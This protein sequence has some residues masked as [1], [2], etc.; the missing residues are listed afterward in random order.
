M[1]VDNN[2]I[3]GWGS[4]CKC[5]YNGISDKDIKDTLLMKEGPKCSLY[6]VNSV[7]RSGLREQEI[8]DLF[9]PYKLQYK[10][11]ELYQP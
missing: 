2:R 10:T 6:T 4:T 7:S 3:K 1:G 5:A 9:L 11:I 8:Y